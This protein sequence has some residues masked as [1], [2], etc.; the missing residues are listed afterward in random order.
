MEMQARVWMEFMPS[1]RRIYNTINQFRQTYWRKAHMGFQV[2]TIKTEVFEQSRHDFS[3]K[4]QKEG[5][6]GAKQTCFFR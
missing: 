5:D 3:G 4:C 6:I 2:S 1:K